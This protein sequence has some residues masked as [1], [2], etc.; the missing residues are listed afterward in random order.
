[1]EITRKRLGM[2]AVLD[3]A[4]ELAGIITDGDLR[5]MLEGKPAWEKLSAA[6]VMHRSPR[7]I[8]AAE[9][10]VN[11]LELMR[12]NQITQLIVEKKGHYEGVIHLH[13][14]IREGLL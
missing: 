13:D 5:R 8:A 11:A 9:L 10:A 4:G 3:Q 12:R 2:T 14:L 6:D 7:T 1:M